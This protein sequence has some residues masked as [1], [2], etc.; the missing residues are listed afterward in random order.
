MKFVFHVFIEKIMENI[1]YEYF[2]LKYMQ[3]VDTIRRNPCLM[4]ENNFG[5]EV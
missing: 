1:Y 4:M 2:V 3:K 5:G